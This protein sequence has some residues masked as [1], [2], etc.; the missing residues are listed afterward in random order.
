[1]TDTKKQTLILIDGHALAYRAY[2]GMPATF[3]TRHGE[4]THAVYGFINMLLAV[5]REY[6]PDYFIVTFDLGDTFR[7]KMYTEY[8]A[9]REKMPD[10]L[11]GQIDRIEQLVRA[12]NM[13]VFTKEGYEADDLLGTLANQAATQGIRALIV[14]GDRDAFQLIKPDIN[15]VISG[16]KFSDRILYDEEKVQERYGVTP[17]QLIDLK[18]LV[19]DSSDNIP[20]VKGIGEKGGAKLIQKY[21]T[22]DNI[23]ANMDSHSKGVRKKLEIDRENAFLSRDLGR[24]ITD[25]PDIMLDLKAGRTNDFD[26]VEVAKQFVELEFNTIFNRIPGAPKDKLPHEVAGLPADSLPPAPF[27]PRKSRQPESDLKPTTL[28]TKPRFTTPTTASD[29]DYITVDDSAKLVD[30]ITALSASDRLAVDVETDSVEETQTNLVGIAITATTQQGYYIPLLHGLKPATT[31]ASMFDM[32]VDEAELLPQLSLAEVQRALAPILAN[33]DLTKYMHNAKFDMIVLQRHGLP[34]APPIFDTMLATWVVYNSPGAKYGLKDLALEQLNIRMTP[35]KNLIGS[36]K[37]QI[38]MKQVPID[39]A[40]PYASADV[41][42]TLRL[43][44]IIEPILK[45][46]NGTPQQLMQSMELP[47]IYVLKDMELAGIRLDVPLLQ[48]MSATMTAKLSELTDQIHALVDKKFNLNSPQQLSDVLFKDLGLPTK[49]LKKTKSGHYSTAAGVLEKLEGLH[50]VIGLMLQNRQLTK[51]KSTYI[52]A[53]PLLINP[54]TQRIHTSYNQIGISTGRLSSHDPNLQNIPIRTP[55]GR[56]IRGAFVAEKGHKLIAADYSQVELRILAH[57][58][59]DPGLLKAFENDEDIHTATASSVL[60]LPFEEIDKYQRRI[61]K[62]V[63]FGLVYGQTAFGLAKGTGMTNKEAKIFIDTYFQKYPEVKQYI[64]ATKALA[65]EQGYVTTLL[66]RRREFPSLRRL[67]GPQKGQAEREAINAPIQGTAAD[68][69]K[70]AMINLHQAIKDQNLATRILLQVH[71]EL[72][73][74]APNDEVDRAVALTREIMSQA[75]SLKIPLK[76]DVEV[77][78]NWLDMHSV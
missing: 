54:N 34:V 32:P 71:D 74:E 42:M 72:V 2:F 41:D 43:A 22:L 20:G 48:N 19:G 16:R 36:G 15:V 5:W 68:I 53:L 27:K 50:D 61:A 77:G 8:K 25:V 60:G 33:P 66:G 70:L 51:L 65:A 40:T 67:K 58:A 39:I 52:D 30:L 57:I 73:L 45:T 29:G 14:T 55:Q 44:E 24:I 1:M 76:V 26:L 6:T 17:N 75:Y 49:G 78:D 59:E 10:D 28:L 18:G 37:K 23:Y 11:R 21:S 62:A 46:D 3:T 69:M 38:T 31:Q 56:A 47:L 9:T 64:A 35:I 12:F 13:P 4:P 63:N 7:H